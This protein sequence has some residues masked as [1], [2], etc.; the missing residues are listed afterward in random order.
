QIRAFVAG[1]L[2][3][4][5]PG[6]FAQGTMDLGATICTPRRPACALCPVNDNCLALKQG[7][8]EHYPVKTAKVAKPR[9]KGAAFV[10][11]RAD[12]AILL[13]KRID[14]GLLGGMTELPGTAWTAR[15]DGGTGADSAPFAAAWRPAG[16]IRHVFTHFELEISVHA[17]TVGDLAAPAGHWW[18]K[19]EFIHSEALPTVMKK[20]IEAA[21]PGA[22]KK[23]S[24]SRSKP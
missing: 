20:V 6:D 4:E 18:S 17:A 24:S 2:P 23:P 5:R 14:S 8:P 9:R 11:V 1:A 10:A 12:G 7:D 13:R 22:T 3:A 15:I 21:I 19:A 16:S